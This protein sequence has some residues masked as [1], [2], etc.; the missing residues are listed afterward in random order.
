MLLILY[1]FLIDYVCCKLCNIWLLLFQDNS[2]SYHN[3]GASRW[4]ENIGAVISQDRVIDDKFKRQIKNLLTRIFQCISNWSK[5]F[6]YLPTLFLQSTQSN[7][8]SKFFKKNNFSVDCTVLYANQAKTSIFI[9]PGTPPTLKLPI[10]SH[11]SSRQLFFSDVFLIS[12]YHGYKGE[13]IKLTPH[14][15]ID[16][17]YKTVMS[18]HL[19]KLK[20]IQI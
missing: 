8:F 3:T 6:E 18:S 19:K 4:K 20:I 5:V 1:L 12:N 9:I 15:M 16:I 13:A 10:K 14:N 11:A 17:I 2:R 7:N